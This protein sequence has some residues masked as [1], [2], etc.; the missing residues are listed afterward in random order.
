M[1]A[2]QFTLERVMRWRAVELA[3]EQSK[4]ETLIQ[5]QVRIQRQIAALGEE[6]S[7]LPSISAFPDLRGQDFRAAAAYGLRLKRQLTNLEQL[8]AK[9][10]RELAAQR[11]KYN[12]AKQ[13][14]R[15]LEELKTRQFS[16]WQYEQNLQM[17]ALASESYLA[18]W[19][20]ER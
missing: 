14:L 12:E 5:N 3:R 4:L 15:L 13:R 10:Q 20:R 19:G 2:F 6:R 7:K 9:C 17:E 1:S 16:R 18:S 8:S 11:K